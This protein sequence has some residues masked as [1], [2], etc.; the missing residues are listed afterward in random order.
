MI[1]ILSRNHKV[2]CSINFYLGCELPTD[3]T[4][5]SCVVHY[6]NINSSDL[7][8]SNV[9]MATILK[10]QTISKHPFC[11]VYVLSANHQ[12]PY[13][14]SEFQRFVTLTERFTRNLN[15]C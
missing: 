11:M 14:F 5:H 6:R 3:Q 7:D 10:Y 13:T 8:L 2:N 12:I 4:E 1:K 9:S 15:S